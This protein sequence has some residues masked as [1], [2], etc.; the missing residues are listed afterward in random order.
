[1]VQRCW[2]GYLGRCTA[3]RARAAR[4]ARLRKAWCIRIVCH[5]GGGKG[6]PAQRQ[7][8]VHAAHESDDPV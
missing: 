6:C 7:R 8:S 3:A 1:M 5:E 2:R 4:D